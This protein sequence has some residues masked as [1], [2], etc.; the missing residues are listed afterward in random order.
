MEIAPALQAR[1]DQERRMITDNIRGYGVHLT[2][3]I[4]REGSQ[5][6]CRCCADGQEPEAR[7]S[8]AA[9]FE[10]TGGPMEL[11]PPRIEVPFG[12]TTG[13]FGVGHAELV[14]V[15]LER[16]ETAELLNDVAHGVLGHGGDLM[17]GEEVEVQGRR[18]LVEELPNSGMILFETHD[19]YQRPPWEPIDAVQLT[20]ADEDGRF[21]WDE[22]HDPGPWGQARPGGYR[23]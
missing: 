3:V 13:L 4:D 1:W 20:W 21:P 18:V 16:R 14:V 7:D 23:A 6:D 12:Y 17:P 9:L 22:G 2:Y 15:G 5:G 10:A 8:L 19:F 11:L